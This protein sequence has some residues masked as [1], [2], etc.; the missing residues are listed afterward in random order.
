MEVNESDIKWQVENWGGWMN[1]LD[2]LTAYTV[3]DLNL[4][5][6]AFSYMKK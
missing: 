6:G 2:C 5:K 1:F 4:R 3:H